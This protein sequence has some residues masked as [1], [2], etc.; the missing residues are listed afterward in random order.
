MLTIYKCIKKNQ[1]VYLSSLDEA[2]I[3]LYGTETPTL[4]QIEFRQQVTQ[5]DSALT[6][7]DLWEKG[8]FDEDAVNRM[9]ALE[10]LTP[11]ERKLLGL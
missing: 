3:Y 1:T 11:H 8:E 6:K 10:K 5:N 4:G 7:I 2:N 9:K